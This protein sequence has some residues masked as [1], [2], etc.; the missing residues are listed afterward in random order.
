VARSQRESDGAP[1]RVQDLIE[2]I[3]NAVWNLLP[4]YDDATLSHGEYVRFLT[5]NVERLLA[6]VTEGRSFTPDDTAPAHELGERRADQGMPFESMVRS[7]HLSERIML[8]TLLATHDDL[9]SDD[10]RSTVSLLHE[11]N[12]ALAEASYLSFLGALMTITVSHDVITR[13]RSALIA[14]II[15]RDTHAAQRVA[16][17]LGVADQLGRTGRALVF[18]PPDGVDARSFQ[19]RAIAGLE[20]QEVTVV[21]DGIW[22]QALVIVALEPHDGPA[23]IA[24]AVQDLTALRDWRV[25]IGSRCTGPGGVSDSIEDAITAFRFIRGA[26]EHQR[27]P[28]VVLFDDVQAETLL[29]GDTRRATALID[30]HL[31]PILG[32]DDLME[33]LT[34]FVGT[35]GS[36]KRTAEQLFLHPN[37]VTYRLNKISRR[38]GR[39][40]RNF[41]DLVELAFAIRAHTA[42]RL[43]SSQE[44]TTGA[45]IPNATDSTPP[46]DA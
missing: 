32:D 37:S 19:R 30:H 12:G 4:G 5:N 16:N 33:T 40:P 18:R 41:A 22:N 17:I 11:N 8:D 43:A 23:H 1:D 25:A 10:L 7:Y 2:R 13:L 27:T 35:G 31:G 44:D 15:E 3:D 38:L 6:A 24:A 14:A 42:I 45:A 21:T 9:S 28:A 20:R 34:A 46:G 26:S 29:A 39:D 36:T